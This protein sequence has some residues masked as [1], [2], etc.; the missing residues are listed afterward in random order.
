[1]RRLTSR[2][3][4]I[5]HSWDYNFSCFALNLD[6]SLQLKFSRTPLDARKWR[7]A[8]GKSGREAR[9]RD[10]FAMIRVFT[11]TESEQPRFERRASNDRCNDALLPGVFMKYSRGLHLHSADVARQTFLPSVTK[12]VGEEAQRSRQPCVADMQRWMKALPGETGRA[13]SPRAWRTV[14]FLPERT[15][16]LR[17]LCSVVRKS[18]PL[19][20]RQRLALLQTA[21]RQDPLEAFG[22]FARLFVWFSHVCRFMCKARWSEREKHLENAIRRSA[23]RKYKKCEC[24]LFLT[25]GWLCSKTDACNLDNGV[26]VSCGQTDNS[27]I[28]TVLTVLQSR[29]G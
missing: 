10:A 15:G 19:Y 18:S 14:F 11:R 26:S 2:I 6:L 28:V 23:L 25:R 13:Q 3:N 27:V 22:G 8:G 7:H 1:M 4:L 9:A 5:L 17:K 20:C 21:R 24:E 16:T 29:F 12:S